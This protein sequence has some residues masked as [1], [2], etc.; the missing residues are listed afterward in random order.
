MPVNSAILSAFGLLSHTVEGVPKDVEI[1]MSAG[2]MQRCFASKADGQR[3]CCPLLND[4]SARNL[5]F[6][7]LPRLAE[8]P[9]K[10]TKSSRRSGK[11]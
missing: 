10:G 5:S 9:G 11:L 2:K 8:Q 4:N 3:S 1:P 7:P 6:H